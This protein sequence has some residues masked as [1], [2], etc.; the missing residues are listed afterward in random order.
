MLNNKQF[1]LII[2]GTQDIS[3]EEQISVCLRHVD[4][5]LDVHEDFVGLYAIDS[6]TGGFT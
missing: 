4:D 5:S 2:D 6:A 3:G 1:A